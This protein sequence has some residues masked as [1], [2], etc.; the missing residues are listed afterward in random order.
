L[1][2]AFSQR[3]PRPPH[4]SPAQSPPQLPWPPGVTPAPA[5]RVSFQ[6]LA[7]CCPSCPRGHLPI[8]VLLHLVC[9]LAHPPLLLSTAPF[10]QP[11]SRWIQSLQVPGM[12]ITRD[13]S[14]S[15]GATPGAW[16]RACFQGRAV[17]PMASPQQSFLTPRGCNLQV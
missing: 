13:S 12:H 7:R 14:V 9:T 17:V 3:L 2:Q 8:V 10:A 11:P 16:R 5:S 1:L 15:R 6:E 4:L